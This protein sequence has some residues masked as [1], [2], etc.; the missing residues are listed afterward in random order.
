MSIF[1]HLHKNP[2]TLQRLLDE[3]DTAFANGAL[4]YPV[5]FNDAI[6]L[7]YLHA[8]VLEGMRMH[9]SLGTGLP[10]VVPDEGAEICGRFFP[11]GYTV[12]MNAN[13]V[14]FDKGV[15]GEDSEQF[16]PERW[17][18]DGERGAANMERHML[19]FGYGPRICIGKHVSNSL[20]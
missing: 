6:K 11:G 1:Y 17:F 19:Q 3:L 10:R 8:V 4:K 7:P 14:N 12:I 16:I 9:S 13:A 18:R 20:P 5:R 15:F 2:H